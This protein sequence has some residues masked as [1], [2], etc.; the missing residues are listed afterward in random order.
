MTKSLSRI[1]HKTKTQ[2]KAWKT[3]DKSLSRLKTK[4]GTS[5]DFLGDRYITYTQL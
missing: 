3:Q 2:D 4:A 5:K 1:R